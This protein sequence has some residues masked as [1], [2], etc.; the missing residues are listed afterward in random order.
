MKTNKEQTNQRDYLTTREAAQILAVSYGTLKAA[1]ADGT[2]HG[3]TAPLF[4][5]ISGPQAKR[6]KIVY[7]KQDLIDWMESGIE[8]T[9]N[10]P[11]Q[12]TQHT[13]A[14]SA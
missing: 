5:D 10:A 7:R 9:V 11:A 3:R 2:L 14:L 4:L 8:R 1:R 13:E 6:T 12:P